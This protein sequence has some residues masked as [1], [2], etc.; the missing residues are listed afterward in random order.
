[1]FSVKIPYK[2]SNDD[3]RAIIN[4]MI[5]EYNS[6]FRVA[7]NR[8][9]NNE[10]VNYKDISN[11]NNIQLLNSWY[12]LSALKEAKDVAKTIKKSN[13]TQK[14]VIFG[15]RKKF[16]DR[17]KGLISHDDLI[18]SRLRPITC[19][20]E[21]SSITKSVHGNRKFKLDENLECIYLKVGKSKIKLIIPK[22]KRNRQRDL[23]LVYK[24]QCL[25]D[26]PITY[27][28]SKDYVYINIDETVLYDTYNTYQIK[29]RVLA[30]DLNPNYI[31]CS[32]V[33]WKSEDDFNV[34]FTKTYSIKTLN[35]KEINENV[36]LSDKRNYELIEI[37]KDIIK[38]AVHFKCS[39]VGIENLN[40]KDSK[41]P[42]KKINRL[43]KNLWN[44]II[45]VNNLKKRCNIF[46]IKLIEVISSYSSFV[47]NILYRSLNLPDM[48]LASIEIGRRSY[49]FYNQY[50]IKSKEHKKNIIYPDIQHT[51]FKSL[52]TKSLEEF[53]INDCVLGWTELYSSFKKS[54]M[55]YRLSVDK[56][57]QL[58]SS[59]F[60][61]KSFV[62]QFTTQKNNLL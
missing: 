39:I 56:F 6:M 46:S 31:G 54:K 30:L 22:Q 35:D 24:H 57:G 45:F 20:G 18:E 52:Y 28:L 32:I 2:I 42:I 12:A 13:P 38:Q 11:L 17:Q 21:Q 34:V 37:S 48:V 4:R 44:R 19:Y 14:K 40:F 23:S 58:F 60:Y 15:S 61:K 16:I 33:D 25:D 26:M 8:V 47:G 27:R 3:D 62:L 41:T 29:N 1:M 7:F 53:S 49:E 59:C 5:R 43:C 51:N 10:S 9:W 50:I 55:M 36:S